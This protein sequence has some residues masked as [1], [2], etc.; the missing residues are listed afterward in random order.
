MRNW[1]ETQHK[2]TERIDHIYR[3]QTSIMRNWDE[4]LYKKTR[5]N[6]SYLQKTKTHCSVLRPRTCNTS[7]IV[8]YK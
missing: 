7:P 8:K 6:R 1:D 4:T 5:K 2:K 3:K